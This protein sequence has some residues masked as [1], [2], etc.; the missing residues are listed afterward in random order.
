MDEQLERD[1]RQ[2]LA[3]GT[4]SAAGQQFA[5]GA[6]MVAMQLPPAMRHTMLAGMLGELAV[7]EPAL[8]AHVAAALHRAATDAAIRGARPDVAE[9]APVRRVRRRPAPPPAPQGD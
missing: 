5:R 2:L 9:V 1:A 6:W 4:V 7:H 8:A 3:A